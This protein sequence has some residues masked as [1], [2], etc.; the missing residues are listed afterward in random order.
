MKKCVFST[1]KIQD[2]LIFIPQ[3]T[4]VHSDG[5][6]SVPLPLLPL[7][8]H[9]CLN[10]HLDSTD[11]E[12]EIVRLGYSVTLRNPY[13]FNCRTK[14]AKFFVLKIALDGLFRISAINLW[15]LGITTVVPCAFQSITSH[16]GLFTIHH[17]FSGKLSRLASVW[18]S[19]DG[20]G[21]TLA[22]LSEYN[23]KLAL[24]FRFSNPLFSF[25]GTARASQV[26]VINGTHQFDSSLVGKSARARATVTN[27]CIFE[28]RFDLNNRDLSIPGRVRDLAARF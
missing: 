16:F 22:I 4:H 13:K 20:W 6:V 9:A 10:S 27:F 1:Y 24:F 15:V 28:R 18:V 17:S 3:S 25:H 8:K 21:E 14:L 11:S 5:K 26:H 23:G 2:K 19:D 12:E 7:R